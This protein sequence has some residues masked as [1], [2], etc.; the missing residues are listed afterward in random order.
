MERVSWVQSG[1]RY[2]RMEGEVHNLEQLSKGIYEIGCGMSGWFLTK[3]ANCFTFNYKIYDMQRDFLNY[4]KKTYKNTTGN[5]G[6][7]LNGTRG[8]GKSVTAKL[9]AN[10]MNLPVILVRNM[11]DSNDDMISYISSFNFDCILFLDEFEKQFGEQDSSML[12]IMD[13]VYTSE[14]RKIFLLTTNSLNINENLLDRPSRI[15]YVKHFGNLEKNIVDEYLEDNL[16]NKTGKEELMDYIDTLTISTI[17]I[18]KSIVEEVNIHGVEK[19]L[20]SKSI[21]NVSTAMYNY[22][23]I[24]SEIENDTIQA[25][26]FTV[27]KFV[28]E[29]KNYDN[30]FSIDAEYHDRMDKAKTEKDVEKVKKEFADKRHR[31]GYTNSDRESIDKPWN[32]LVPGKDTFYREWL[33]VVKVD[34]KNN[35]VVCADSCGT[36]TWFFFIKNPKE[37]P[38]IYKENTFPNYW[39][40]Y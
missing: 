3:T 7:L 28:K 30:R 19:F 39:D 16:V 20:E 26:K 4:V 33:T 27:E 5:F 29:A 22:N 17:D 38:S 35:V 10:E 15:R 25:S 37:K 11:G 1:N 21:F 12:Q 24:Y 34:E 40:L 32:K 2:M 13:G 6:I 23:F 36:E 31:T 18:L 14:Y 8:T 9:L